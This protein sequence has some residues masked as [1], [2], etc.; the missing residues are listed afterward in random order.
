MSG[1][2]GTGRVHRGKQRID[3]SIHSLLSVANI[4]PERRMT[5]FLETGDSPFD[6]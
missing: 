5:D 3:R 6:E 2:T 4:I 1:W